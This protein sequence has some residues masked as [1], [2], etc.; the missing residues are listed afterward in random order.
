MDPAPLPGSTPVCAVHPAV[1]A[2]GTCS[3]CGNFGCGECLGLLEGKLVCRGCVQAGRVQVGLSPFDR[4]EEMGLLAA[5]WRTLVGVCA[6][7]QE[8]FGDLAPA[9]RLGSAFLFLFLVSIP[10]ALANGAWNLAMKAA[11]SPIVEP[12]VRQVYGP[13]GSPFSDLMVSAYEPNVLTVLGS[14]AVFPALVLL[15]AL[16]TGLVTHLGLMLVG[17]AKRGLDASLKVAIY[18]HGVLFWLVVPVLGGF[19]WLWMAVVLGIGLAR[20]HDA[21][22]WQATFAVLYAPCLCFCGLI[23]GSVALGALLGAAIGSG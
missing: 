5:S 21:R 1:P 19:A 15:Y 9:G 4:R 20:V 8:F 3:H 23:A 16:I 10:A 13:P 2:A 17:G 7:P 14:V 6:R 12:F 18:A 22:G 11:L